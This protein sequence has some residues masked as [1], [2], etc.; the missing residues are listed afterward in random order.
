MSKKMKRYLSVL[1]LVL[2]LLGVTI[3]YSALNQGLNISGTSKITNATWDVH[4]ANVQVKSGSVTAI[5]A[6]T[7]PV[8]GA[9]TMTYEV[10]LSTP[11]DFYEF[12]FDVE[13]AGSVDAKLSAL[14]TLSGVSAAQD[15]YTNYT[16]THTDGS[17]IVANE[18]IAAGEETNFTVRVEFD[19]NVSRD[20]L[21]TSA[22]TMTLI[23][24]ME[25]VQS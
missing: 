3:G 9:T 4:F 22:Q 11:G 12:S 17:P 23:V 25:Y 15:V 5:T 21:P 13:N 14:P 8:S 1:V 16:I 6:P 24:D 20:Q 7:A 18:L 19:R 2:L 10:N